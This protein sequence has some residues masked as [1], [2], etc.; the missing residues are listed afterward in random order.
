MYRIN[1]T[2]VMNTLNPSIKINTIV[3]DTQ[4]T[5]VLIEAE[6]RKAHLSF[7]TKFMISFSELN[8]LLNELQKLN[9]EICVGEMFVEE[10]LSRDFTQYS[11]NAD[12]LSN[13]TVITRQYLMDVPKK[14]IRA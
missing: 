4:D 12:L 13:S 8:G 7:E 3:Y 6:Q 9:P 14:Q 11:L 5:N 10:K 2:N 1:K